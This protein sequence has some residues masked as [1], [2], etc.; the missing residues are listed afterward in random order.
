MAD[1]K[2]NSKSIFVKI[3]IFASLSD[4]ELQEIIKSPDNGYEEYA[5]RSKP[6]FVR[7]RSAI[8][9]MSFWKVLLRSLFESGAGG[10]EIS[11]ATLR[12]GDFFGEQSST[13]RWHRET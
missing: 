10:R 6:S 1:D 9:C 13:P 12:A 8:V 5:M 11:I 3:P 2:Y 4:A 7:K